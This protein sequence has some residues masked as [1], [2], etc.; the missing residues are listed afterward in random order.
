MIRIGLAFVLLGSLAHAETG[1]PPPPKPA[2]PVAITSKTTGLYPSKTCKEKIKGGDGQDPVLTCPALPG[3][4]V[5]ISFSARDTHVTLTGGADQHSFNGWVGDKIEWRL[6]GGKPFAIIVAVGEWEES[7]T[8]PG[9]AKVINERLLIRGVGAMSIKLE[10]K[11]K[12]A[13][14]SAAAW[15]KARELADAEYRSATAKK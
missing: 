3:H 6:A 2:K 7:D 1:K 10:V 4:E 9:A 11:D 13:N 12:N 8:E 14:K 5:E 15:K